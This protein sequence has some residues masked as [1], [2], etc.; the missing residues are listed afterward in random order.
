MAM[1]WVDK[2]RPKTLDAMDYHQE[3]SQRLTKIGASPAMPHM[4]FLGPNGAGKK[5]RVLALLRQIYGQGVEATKVETRS[6]APNPNSPS[7]TVDIQVLVSN[8]HLELSPADVGNKDRAVVMQLIKE[9]AAHPPIG[10]HAFKVVVIDEAGAL[11]MQ[12]QA[13]LRRTMEK[14]MRSC[15]IFLLCDSA[16]KIIP[17]LRSRCLAIRVPAPSSEHVEAILQQTATKEGVQLPKELG[18]RIAEKSGRDL[19]RALL[20]LESTHAQNSQLSKDQ[21]LPSEAWDIALEKCAQKILEEQSPKRA[22]EVRGMLYEFLAACLPGDFILKELLAKL[23]PAIQNEAYRATAVSAAAHFDALMRQGSKEILHLEAF[24]LR[25][26][27][28]YDDYKK[29]R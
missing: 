25:F 15:R 4:L 19:R 18:Q 14:Y 21:Q 23:L 1:L 27:A 17:P 20:L 11:S 5:T 13:A 24:V 9:I 29:S 2:H 10:H 8:H 7:T 6:V 22:M 16:S 12:A 3:L 28:T 26:M